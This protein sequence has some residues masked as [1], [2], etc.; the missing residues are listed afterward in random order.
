VTSA[1]VKALLTS[2]CPKRVVS[3]NGTSK[4][5]GFVFMVTQVNQTL[6]VSVIVRPKRLRKTSPTAKSS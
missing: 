4:C 2:G 5:I 1:R 6:S 3:A